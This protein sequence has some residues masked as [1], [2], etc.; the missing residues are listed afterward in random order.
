MAVV[1]D[2]F[3]TLVC[4]ELVHPLAYRRVER[5]ADALGLEVAPMQRWFAETKVARNRHREPRLAERL[6]DYCNGVGAFP[7]ARAI[8][9]ALEAGDRFHL[10]AV[11]SPTPEVLKTVQVLRERGIRV[12]VLSNTDEHE[13]RSWPES[14]L[15]RMVDAAGLSVD[16]GFVKPEPEAYR[17]ILRALGEVAPRDAIFVGDGESQE[18]VGAKNAG[19]REAVFMRGFVAHSGFQTPENLGRFA[20]EADHTIDSISEVLELV[21]RARSTS[22]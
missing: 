19:F 11:R 5:I 18:L 2:L 20:S 12:G 13:I 3:R 10:E 21:P 8:E 17:W 15:S 1:F 4:P 14:P 22:R 9:D 16:I 7:S 6:R